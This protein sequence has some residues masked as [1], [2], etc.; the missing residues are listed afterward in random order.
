MIRKVI[1]V[2]CAIAASSL[3]A[4]GVCSLER[5]WEWRFGSRELL[6]PDEPRDYAK[7]GGPESRIRFKEGFVLAE[8]SPRLGKI[9]L[10]ASPVSGHNSRHGPLRWGWNQN[11]LGTPAG[12]WS[13][14]YYWSEV[15]FGLPLLLLMAYPVYALGSWLRRSRRRWERGACLRCGYDLRGNVTGTCSECGTQAHLGPGLPTAIKVRCGLLVGCT[16]LA[17]AALVLAL[18]SLLWPLTLRESGRISVQGDDIELDEWVHLQEDG[19]PVVYPRDEPPVVRWRVAGGWLVV[20]R[21]WSKRQLDSVWWRE[22]H[23]EWLTSVYSGRGYR[24]NQVLFV[25]DSNEFDIGVLRCRDYFPHGPYAGRTL[26][27]CEL[28]M[29]A[30]VALLGLYPAAALIGRW[31]GIFT[32]S[33][34]RSHE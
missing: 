23:D 10:G 12:R 33:F 17:M 6:S 29:W 27:M 26:G 16:A 32:L 22:F 8:W 18:L 20:E 28:S 1:L 9:P 19:Y 13:V 5:D 3:L 2:G 24:D 4:C 21:R 30:L 34:W 7:S 15:F 11:L 31:R 25:R 14:D